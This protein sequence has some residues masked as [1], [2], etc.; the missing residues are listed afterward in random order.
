M[1]ELWLV[2]KEG[3]DACFEVESHGTILVEGWVEIDGG[4][5]D[6]PAQVRLKLSV[7]GA[8]SYSNS[9]DEARTKTALIDFGVI[10]HDSPVVFSARARLRIPFSCVLSENTTNNSNNKH[11]SPLPPS[12]VSSRVIV[13]YSIKATCHI[14]VHGQRI[15]LNAMSP[16]K[17][18]S[19]ASQRASILATQAPTCFT[20]GDPNSINYMITLARTSALPGSSFFGEIVLYVPASAR[21]ILSKIVVTLRA[22]L[23]FNLRQSSLNFPEF[24]EILSKTSES[25]VSQT[26]PS[27]TGDDEDTS[28]EITRLVSLPIPTTAAA[29][30]ETN[31]FSYSYIARYEIWPT[32]ETGSSPI[33]FFDVPVNVIDSGDIKN[34]TFV[35]QIEKDQ[36]FVNGRIPL[37]ISAAVAGDY[38][39]LYA[40]R[41]VFDDGF[42]AFDTGDILRVTEFYAD[43]HALA[44][45]ESSLIEGFVQMSYL[46]E[47][48]FVFGFTPSA[49]S[50]TVISTPPTAEALEMQS[51]SLAAAVETISEAA[52]NI[53]IT[54]STP[55]PPHQPAPLLSDVNA[56][57]PTYSVSSSHSLPIIPRQS[58]TDVL[59]QYNESQRI[60]SDNARK[61]SLSTV[62]ASAGTKSLIPSFFSLG[63]GSGASGSYNAGQGSTENEPL[64]IDTVVTV[65]SASAHLSLLHRFA[66]LDNFR[67]QI[68][69]WQFLCHA[70]LRYIKWLRFLGE[71]RPDPANIPLPPLDVALM[72]QA[73]MLNPL[74]YLED[75]HFIF[76]SSSPYHMPLHRMHQIPGNEYSPT[77]RSQEF[78]AE[79]DPEEP[80]T[81]PLNCK[82]PAR[83]ECAWC[84]SETVVNIDVYVLFRMKDGAYT[85]TGCGEQIFRYQAS[86]KRFLEDFELFVFGKQVMIGSVLD[87]KTGNINVEK[88]HHDLTI[89]FHR[90]DTIVGLFSSMAETPQSCRWDDIFSALQD[91]LEILRR[92]GRLW[93]ASVRVTTLPQIIQ[94][95]RGIPTSLSLDLIGAAIRQRKF[96]RKIVS[97]AVDWGERN[98]LAK[99]IFRYRRFIDLM[100][101]K[102]TNFLVPTLDVDLI[103]HTHQLF[104]E[105]YKNFGLREIGRV[106]NH[107]DN[108]AAEILSESFETTANLWKATFQEKYSTQFEEL[109]RVKPEFVNPSYVQAAATK[110]GGGLKKISS[111][112]NN[113]SSSCTVHDPTAPPMPDRFLSE[114]Y[115]IGSPQKYGEISGTITLAGSCYTCKSACIPWPVEQRK[116]SFL[117]FHPWGDLALLN[118]QPFFGEG[119]NGFYN[120]GGGGNQH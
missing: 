22:R 89:I 86:A 66:L 59:P 8:C 64:I 55:S 58:E 35:P 28:L 70:E 3:K 53:R 69:D 76:D 38:L 61:S 33:S 29:S 13:S 40:Y 91:H 41:P 42:L 24:I 117:K 67:D 1:F 30:L 56:S 57:P 87:E 37:P 44:Y 32:A 62:P 14:S 82:A 88:A 94:A 54:T 116:G 113:N 7:G 45:H 103:W 19:K 108:V 111:M 105:N 2:P 43:G 63:F 73:H 90:A 96:S 11:T 78:W 49:F 104:P 120:C 84:K 9:A 118:G 36:D 5:L 25:L 97:G 31:I 112:L 109:T 72:W 18:V 21:N 17:V 81:L 65:F 51:N 92:N 119:E 85:C 80:Y 23:G 48:R 16:L 106:I 46:V 68:S 71:K 99:A 77:D 4:G 27:T 107:D 34:M 52:Q 79:V 100:K 20:N 47:T 12:F 93:N 39:A 26:S 6:A 74:R 110:I 95:Y 115:P 83:I 75:C 98:A 50:P 101:V 60:S 10:A 15:K 114:K 102:P